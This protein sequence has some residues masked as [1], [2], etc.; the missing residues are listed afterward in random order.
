MSLLKLKS[1]KEIFV[2][3]LLFV[4]IFLNVWDLLI[5]HKIFNAMAMG[6]FIFAPS[7]ILWIFGKTWSVALVTLVSL[8]QFI[9]LGVLILQGMQISG[10]DITLKTVFFAPFLLMAGV[11]MILGLSIYTKKVEAKTR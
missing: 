10:T 9:I 3:N 11:N 7:L 6:M 4:F 8:I 1:P 5:S 2:L